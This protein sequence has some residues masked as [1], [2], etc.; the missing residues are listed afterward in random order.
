MTAPCVSVVVPHYGD[1]AH[2][3]GLLDQRF[4]DRLLLGR[5]RM[6]QPAREEAAGQGKILRLV[7]PRHADKI[8]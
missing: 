5:H 8:A 6:A 4:D 2:A 3:L 7:G 1:P